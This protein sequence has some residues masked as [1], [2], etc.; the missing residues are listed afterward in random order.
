MDATLLLILAL[1][2]LIEV[3]R[4]VSVEAVTFTCTALRGWAAKAPSLL[5]RRITALRFAFPLPALTL[6]IHVSG[7]TTSAPDTDDA[8]FHQRYQALR[9]AAAW[10]AVLSS[11]SILSLFL[12]YPLAAGRWGSVGGVGAILLSL[13]FAVLTAIVTREGLKRVGSDHASWRRTIKFLWPLATPLAPERLL[14]AAATGYHPLAVARVLLPEAEFREFVRPLVFDAAMRGEDAEETG[15]TRAEWDR[16]L[17][18]AT[19]VSTTR[20]GRRINPDRTAAA[21]CPRCG[22]EFLRAGTCPDCPGVGLVVKRGNGAA[23]TR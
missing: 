14:T 1:L 12:G 17:Y 11:L 9:P 4:R 3:G 5:D 6:Q 2:Y 15:P 21:V 7:V 19:F 22:R 8:G 18:P 20:V 10:S 23:P 13:L 16:L